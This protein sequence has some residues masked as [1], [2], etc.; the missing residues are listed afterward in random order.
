MG[1]NFQFDIVIESRCPVRGQAEKSG[2]KTAG[3]I[4]RLRQCTEVAELEGNLL[5]GVGED[6]RTLGR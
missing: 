4:V 1:R 5:L 6:P 3:D 2:K